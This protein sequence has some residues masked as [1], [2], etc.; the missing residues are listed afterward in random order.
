[1]APRN[2]S[3]KTS[4]PGGNETLRHFTHPHVLIKE[5]VDLTVYSS[6]RFGCDG[7][8][9]DGTGIRY[10]CKPCGFDL[11]VDCGTCPEQITSFIHPN[12][13]LERI[14][15]GPESYGWRP[16][17]VCGE[18]VKSLFYKC[19][20]GDAEK[21][22]HDEGH[23]F[24]L[25]PSCAKLPPQL[26]FNLQ[27]VPVIPDDTWCAICANVVS[28][29]SWSY[30]SDAYGIVIHPQCVTLPKENVH[31]SSRTRSST[32]SQ[33]EQAEADADALAAAMYAAK[34]SAK[35]NKFILKNLI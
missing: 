21:S 18:E 35:T 7:C 16:C 13:P 23:Y 15:E 17:N 31:Q 11:H 19:S 28:P 24:F 2:N 27:S 32:L 33:V 14:W 9:M 8:G 6:N 3:A 12:H 22:Y 26:I 5:A 1:M 34:M 30:R 29:S 4:S 10:H 25:H 20:S